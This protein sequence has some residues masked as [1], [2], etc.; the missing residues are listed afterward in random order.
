MARNTEFC[1]SSFPPFSTI[2]DLANVSSVS[3]SSL[4]I[5]ITLMEPSTFLT[6]N[7]TSVPFGPLI[8]LTT[9]SNRIPA[10]SIGS[11]F[12]CPTFKIKSPASNSFPFQ[13]GPPEI[14]SE[15]STASFFFCKRAPIPSK[16]PLILTS[17]FSVSSVEAL[18]AI[19]TRLFV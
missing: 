1:M 16:V 15:I 2:D 10:T 7:L 3:T 8:F 17:N 11:S 9:S 14:N 5:V 6:V 19:I 13:A 4:I 12:P 18:S